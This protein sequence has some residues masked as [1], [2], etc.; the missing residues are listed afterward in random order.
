[1]VVKHGLILF[2]AV[3]SSEFT[4]VAARSKEIQVIFLFTSCILKHLRKK[5]N[6]CY[7]KFKDFFCS[8]QANLQASMAAA[9]LV[10]S[11]FHPP[12]AVAA[13]VAAPTS[14]GDIVL[15]KITVS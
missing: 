8:L 2:L 1:M 5:A 15:K 11:G 7:E 9:C 14:N 10:S 12:P 6:I 13:A 3:V 4:R